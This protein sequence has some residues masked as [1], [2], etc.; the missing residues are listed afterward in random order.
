LSESILD[1]YESRTTSRAAERLFRDFLTLLDSGSI[2]AAE[3]DGGRWKVNIWV[4]KGI[5]IG[6]RLGKLRRVGDAGPMPFFDK[7]TFPQKRLTQ[8]N[9]VRFVPGGSA[10]R[11]GAF[12]APSVIIM[13]PAYINVGGYVGAGSLVDSHALVGSCAQVG[14]R[15]HLSAAAQLGGVL[16]P[17]G[18]LPVVVEDDV[19]VGG[20]CGIYEGVLVRRRAVLGAGVFFTSSTAVYDCVHQRIIRK[21]EDGILEIPEN[22]VV[23]AGSRA[24]QSDFGLAHGLGI[25]TPMIVKYRDA[26]TDAKTELEMA[27][28]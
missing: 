2:R 17:V 11:K 10:I 25:Y 24:L 20:N 27:L 26:K 12:I 13:P 19:M 23:V 4:K 7:H 5:L 1:C 3:Q 6:F 14:E 15:V 16:E 28:R 22:A 21:N 9:A 18:A 8:R